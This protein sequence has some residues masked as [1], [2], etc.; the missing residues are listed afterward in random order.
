MPARAA[1]R[2]HCVRHNFSRYRVAV[3][4]SLA[5]AAKKLLRVDHFAWIRRASVLLVLIILLLAV[6]HL[7]WRNASAGLLLTASP[8][9][10][11]DSWKI[12][13][14]SIA[15]MGVHATRSLQ[16]GTSLGPCVVRATQGAIAV[17]EITAMGLMVNHAS[18]PSN[19]A[20]LAHRPGG[21]ALELELVLVRDLRKGEEVTTDYFISP[22]F[23]ALPMPWWR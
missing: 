4:S 9:E 2:M 15:G 22:A 12:S 3:G 16:R 19:T 11:R 10:D 18:S 8:T 5:R 13:P 1:R 17:P 7:A 20:V 6:R 21:H 23:I 14:S